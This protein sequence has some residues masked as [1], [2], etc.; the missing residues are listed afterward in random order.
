M[1]PDLGDRL[2]QTSTYYSRPPTRGLLFSVHASTH[3]PAYFFGS[4]AWGNLQRWLD[5]NL[6][7]QAKAPSGTVPDPNFNTCGLP[8]YLVNMNTSVGESA[9]ST[10]SFSSGTA[11]ARVTTVQAFAFHELH[12][13]HRS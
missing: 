9:P 7:I 3:P 4:Q 5:F 13:H 2:T 10:V 11:S 12:S 6:K 8:F 1:L